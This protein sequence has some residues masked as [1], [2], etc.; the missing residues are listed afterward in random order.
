MREAINIIHKLMREE[1]HMHSERV[2]NM[3]ALFCVTVVP[4]SRIT[5]KRM[6]S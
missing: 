6:L 4:V 2:W 1:Q 5:M 3:K